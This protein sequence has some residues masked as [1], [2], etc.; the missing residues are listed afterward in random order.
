MYRREWLARS[1]SGLTALASWR[2][3]AARFWPPAVVVFSKV[4]QELKLNFEQAAD[5]TEA[6]GLGGIDCPVRPGGE[7]EPERAAEE[8]PR[9]ADVLRRRGCRVGLLTTHIVSPD[10]P[11]AETVLRTARALGI[12]WYR[13]GYWR[14]PHDGA[15]ADLASIRAGLRDLAALN[16]QLGM[17][18]VVQNHSGAFI[19]GDLDQMERLLEGLNPD[20]IGLA[21]D[22]CHALIMHGNRWLP[23]FERLA[24]RIRVAYV[25]DVRLPRDMVPLGEGE[26]GRS[27]W[28]SHLKRLG[29]E[30]PLSLHIEY[31]W[32]R[33]APKTSELLVKVIRRDLTILKHWLSNV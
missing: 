21:F 20:E 28:C 2:V 14:T 13:T 32:S 33:D 23:H 22:F 7:I 3:F 30:A 8:L 6:A 25:K 10:S 11:H 18:A 31:D 17:T 15:T 9:Y 26:L 29:L 12:R 24:P 16:R 5:V 1:V 4:F 27:N 19:G